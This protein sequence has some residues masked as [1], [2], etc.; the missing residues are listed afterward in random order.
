[1]DRMA[2]ST[3]YDRDEFA[4][5]AGDFLRSRPAA[6]TI[7]LTVVEALGDDPHR[8]GGDPPW[9]GWWRPDGDAVAGAFLHTPS[10]PMILAH[11][12]EPALG[13]LAE[14]LAA[15]ERR[16]P[17]VTITTDL[18]DRF[19]AA[20]RRRTGGTCQVLRRSRLYRLG[21]LAPP[22]PCPAG[23]ARVADV[24]DLPVLA[25]WTDAFDRET[26]HDHGT[27]PAVVSAR[28][29][30]GLLTLWEVD[31]APV[32][33]A[34]VTPTV[35]GMARVAPVYTPPA[36][37]GRGYAAAVTTEVTRAA[38]AGGADAVVLF[39]D[40]ANPTSNALY[41]RLGY[42]PVLDQVVLSLP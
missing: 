40:L 11:T 34:G 9:F 31:G 2:W 16:P 15:A 6:H 3:T 35:A 19:A 14:T 4:A 17:G 10:F 37:R 18:A 12:P 42:R 24:R 23:A 20:W 41:Q 39:T 13:P 5:T 30:A 21:E 32:S 29:G 7:L 28:V 1:M 36:L 27:P 25:E 26:G 22:R 33:F 38:L 8:Y